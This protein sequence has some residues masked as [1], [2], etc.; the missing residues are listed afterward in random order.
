MAIPLV[1]IHGYSDSAKGFKQWHD[2][3][4]QK[5]NLD[6]ARVHLL[7]YETLAN[8]ITIRD[9]AEG[10]NRALINEAGIHE[11]QQFD[12]IVHSTG[13]LVIRAWLTRYASSTLT[14]SS[15]KLDEARIRRLRHLIALAPATNGSPVAHK[16]RSWLGALIKGNKDLGPDFLESGHQ[17]L[18]ALE[19][20]S[21]FTWDLAEKDMF[22]D[23]STNR[24]KAGRE[25]PFVFTICGDAGLKKLE[26]IAA[27][28]VGTKISGSDGVVRWAGA[29]LNSR[30]LLIDYTGESNSA[31]ST[32]KTTPQGISA[33]GWNNQNNILIL[34]PGLNHGS[35]MRPYESQHLA[36]LVSEALDINSD[37]EFN[38]WNERA[39]QQAVAERSIMPNHKE[40]D[41]WQQFVIRVCD[42]RMDGVADWTISLHMKQKNKQ[43]QP[44][45]ID[46][47]HPF[48]EDRSYRCLHINL[49]QCHLSD[50][51]D[52]DNV[53][54]LE[55]KLTLNTGSDYLHY[56]AHQQDKSKSSKQKEKGLSELSVELKDYLGPQNKTFSLLMPYTTTYVE[57]RVNRDPS[58]DAKGKAKLCHVKPIRGA[59]RIEQ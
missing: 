32:N 2:F 28:S 16:G 18:S 20:G 1:F 43:K 12:A 58:V 56:S 54:S 57:F 42:E 39:R 13:M 6:P 8:E 47:L 53:E 45:P 10:F 33:S 24:F 27:R 41:Q 14:K 29:P 11:N 19:L 49:S 35:I 30:L 22:G 7:N 59:S 40:P 34:W 46:D 52:I 50:T 3:L 48:G 17:V 31:I 44:I 26:D 5:R 25:S 15:Q 4:I 38:A 23:G 36:D 55:M 51:N 21:P 37:A 9:I